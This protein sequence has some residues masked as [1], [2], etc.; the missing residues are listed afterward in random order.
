MSKKHRTFKAQSSQ[1]VDVLDLISMGSDLRLD[2]DDIENLSTSELIKLIDSEDGVE[3]RNELEG[4]AEL[5]ID[6]SFDNADIDRLMEVELV[7]LDLIDFVEEYEGL[8]AEFDELPDAF[9][10]DVITMKKFRK[11]GEA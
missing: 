11:K 7:D 8:D 2:P 3:F 9:D 6:Y 5:A 10:I 1:E 4:L